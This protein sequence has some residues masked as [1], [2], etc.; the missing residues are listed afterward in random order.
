V[1]LVQL[2]QLALKV[3][4]ELEISLIPTSAAALFRN[5]DDDDDASS[6]CG[7]PPC[8]DLAADV[9]LTSSVAQYSY[10]WMSAASV[11]SL[12]YVTSVR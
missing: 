11:V 12:R 6:Y 3:D 4:P 9:F 5:G 1:P 8:A 10:A 7:L 2:H